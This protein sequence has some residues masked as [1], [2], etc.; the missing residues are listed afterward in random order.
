MTRLA[1]CVLAGTIWLAGATRSLAATPPNGGWPGPVGPLSGGWSGAPVEFRIS[2]AMERGLVPPFRAT[3]RDRT[4]LGFDGLWSP[5]PA[6]RLGLQVDALRD[7]LP[8]GDVLMGVGDLRLSTL[9]RLIDDPLDVGVGWRVKLPNAKDEG[10]LGT[11]ETDADLLVALGMAAGP[12]T[13]GLDAGLAIRG[14]PLRF[15]NQDDVPFLW[16][17]GHVPAGPVRLSGRAGGDAPTARN[18]ARGTAAFGA[19]FGDVVMV[20]AELQAGLTPAAPD[21]GA[22]LWV[23][24]A[25]ACRPRLRD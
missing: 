14:N 17:S 9:V 21:W 8:S 25:P 10:E 4:S 5:V 3:S 2:A 20:G 16:V 18:P 15:A 19:E 12:V 13:L 11:D 22:R 23:G 6:I 1:Q 7:A 24:A